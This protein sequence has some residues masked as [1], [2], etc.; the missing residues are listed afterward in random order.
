MMHYNKY[1][2]NV[3]NNKYMEIVALTQNKALKQTFQKSNESYITIKSI[4]DVCYEKYII[5]K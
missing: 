4:K 5:K 3:H 2:F 1:I